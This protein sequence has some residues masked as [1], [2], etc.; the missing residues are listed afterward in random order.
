M[1][2]I[3]LAKWAAALS[4][5][6][7]VLWLSGWAAANEPIGTVRIGDGYCPPCPPYMLP[8]IPPGYPP[9][10]PA[11]FAPSRPAQ[12]M[13]GQ[14]SAP[15]QPQAPQQPATLQQQQQQQQQQQTPPAQAP[16][17]FTPSPT[18]AATA[19]Q[20]LSPNTI[21]DFF[22]PT[23]IKPLILPGAV[24]NQA[25]FLAPVTPPLPPPPKGPLPPSPP[26]L[27]EYFRI[28]NPTGPGTFETATDVLLGSGKSGVSSAS[29]SL[30]GK[31]LLTQ[32]DGSAF[33]GDIDDLGAVTDP[34]PFL[35]MDSGTVGDVDLLAPEDP[36]AMTTL[37]AE[38]I[39][40]IHDAIQVFLPTPG[41][42]IGRQ[43][44]VENN[45]VFPRDR[46]FLNYSAF[47]NV[48]LSATGENVHRFVPG[49]EMAFLQEHASI[50]VRLPFAAT[51]DSDIRAGGLTARNELEFGNLVATLKGLIAR[52]NNTAV[53]IGT[54]L[55]LPTAADV[56]LHD[57]S[58]DE[59]I[60][61]ENHS[62]HVLPF[63][64]AAYFEGRW[65]TQ[66]YVQ[67]DLDTNGNRVL[68]RN[69]STGDLEDFGQLNDSAFLYASA[70]L[71]YWLYQNGYSQTMFPCEDGRYVKRRIV[72]RDRWLTG[73][74]PMAELHYNRTIESGDMVNA[75]GFQIA[76]ISEFSL[77]NLVL[78]GLMTFGN[79]G[80]VSVAWATPIIGQDDR[81]FDSE[82]RVWFDWTL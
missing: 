40:D 49:F 37:F 45:S 13:P 44:I 78:G 5:P 82:V 20:S 26:P 69:E 62:I 31:Q 48:P 80:S 51:L 72:S 43:K 1:F 7:A 77:T 79:G 18:T 33:T 42:S 2:G 6:A 76:N 57:L 65:F 19:P 63:V 53:A 3:R 17:T 39:Y 59:L 35:A 47:T 24:V 12:P 22:G 10:M 41:A 38:P 16:P 27:L 4:A 8:P 70:S 30:L 46:V 68:V 50:E 60:S 28:V 36:T 58:G 29:L 11:P 55:A 73:F 75:G 74:A 81:Q 61:L 52:T 54:S 66:G 23:S 32:Y 15:Q 25:I 56:T 71:G 14:P 21:G 9:S 67:G 34:G 64:G